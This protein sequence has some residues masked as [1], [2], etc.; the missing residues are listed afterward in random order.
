MAAPVAERRTAAVPAPRA[1]ARPA[2]RRSGEQVLKLYVDSTTLSLVSQVADFVACA[3]DPDVFKIATWLRLPLTAEQLEGCNAHHVPQVAAVSGEF[4]AAVARLV[5]ARRFD[6]IEIH[7]NQHHA[8]KSITP[9]LRELCLLVPGA[10]ERVSLDLYDDG[11]I[12]VLERET[13]KQQRDPVRQVAAAAADLRRAVLAREPMLWGIAQ[14][15]AWHHLFPTTY[16]LLR[17]DVLLRDEPGR[18][19][20]G[21]L[22]PYAADM[23][24][25]TLIGLSRRQTERYLGLFGIDAAQRE[26]LESVARDPD[27]LLFTGSAVWEDADDDELAATQLNAIRMLRADGRIPAG[28]RLAFKGHP[29]NTNHHAELAAAL[30]DDVLTMPS[31]AP[32]ELLHMLGLLPASYGG[33]LSTSQFTLPVDRLRFVLST[34]PER[35]PAR[36]AALPQLMVEAGVLPPELLLPVLAR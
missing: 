27:G 24:F 31:Q 14:S 29:A 4:V 30:G 21:Y 12:G 26:Q 25:D 33:V 32:L 20:H 22:E 19:L 1:G 7:A 23:R 6:R 11:S 34:R 16:H 35:R 3:D 15:Y 9:L 8:A 13:L 28:A 10:R 5:T 18:L 36:G 2:A 17:R